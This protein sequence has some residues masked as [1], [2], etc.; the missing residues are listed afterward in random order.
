MALDQQDSFE[1]HSILLHSPGRPLAGGRTPDREQ[2]GV[3]AVSFVRLVPQR[4]SELLAG[5]FRGEWVQV[6]N[7]YRCRVK[8]IRIAA[9]SVMY[10][11]GSGFTSYSSY[12]HDIS[13]SL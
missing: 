11:S 5:W 1:F 3:V 6:Y 13:T 7:P 4:Q 2:V 9:Y 12:T 10:I 8:T